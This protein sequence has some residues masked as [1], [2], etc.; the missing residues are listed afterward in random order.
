MK[1]DAQSIVILLAEDDADD[2]KLVQAALRQARLLNEMRMVEDGEVLMDYL[3]HRGRYRDP[4]SAPLP[5]VIL[6]DL[7]MP[8]K[9]GREALAEIK[10]DPDLRSIPVVILTTST[11]EEDIVRTYCSGAN[12]Y[13]SKPVT[14]DALVEVMKTLGTYWFNIVDLPG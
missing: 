4:T 13:I 6:L 12:S 3:K 7:N 5:G 11:A 1:D 9:D 8:K 2:R 10:A 14:F